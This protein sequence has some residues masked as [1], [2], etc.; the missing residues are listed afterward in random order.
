MK[1]TI[2][3]IFTTVFAILILPHN[4]WHR[5]HPRHPTEI[6]MSELSTI[7]MVAEGAVTGGQLAK[8]DDVVADDIKPPGPAFKEWRLNT[9]FDNVHNWHGLRGHE[10]CSRNIYSFPTWYDEQF[11]VT[12]PEMFRGKQII[13]PVN[14]HFVFKEGSHTFLNSAGDATGES[15]TT[16]EGRG[17]ERKITY[18]RTA[19]ALF[20][21]DISHTFLIT[22]STHGQLL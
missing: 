1:P 15:E 6:G 21:E 17:S 2:R 12:L 10:N 9:N 11:V 3:R 5:R 7:F 13:L 14:A 22:C 18:I 16:C 19:C 20:L 8:D 4:E